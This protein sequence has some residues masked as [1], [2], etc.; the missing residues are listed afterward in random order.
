MATGSG[1]DAQ[2]GTK[3]ETTVGTI[4][5]PVDH[6]W[7]FA[8]AGLT[9]DPTY[10]EGSGI[11]AGQRFKD[12]N[13]VG[14]ARKSANGQIVI[15][16]LHAMKWGWWWRHLIG[17]V[18]APVIIGAGPAYKQVH[19][20]GP[21]KGISFTAQVGKPEPATGTVQPRTYPG[22]K[23]TDWDL[24]FS[25]GEAT[26]LSLSVDGWDED[27]VTG[28]AAASYTSSAQWNFAH[29][30]VF[31]TGGTASFASGEVSIAGGVAVPS[32][33]S[34]LTISGKNTLETGRYGLGNAGLKKEQLEVD[35]CQIT[36]SFEAE[37]DATT[38]DSPFKT[39]NTI[40]IQVDSTGP[41]I[42]GSDAYLLSV[43]MPYCKITKAPSEVSGPGLV[44]TKGEFEVYGKNDQT[45]IA[46]LQIKIVSTDTTL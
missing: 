10:I 4:A 19:V 33:V 11:Y 12:V 44:S 16:A 45:A 31:K 9:Y 32:V 30:N 18:A 28:L 2:F 40:A 7:P 46:P 42:A 15:P 26:A 35:Q 13:L 17:S 39:G 3:T 37:Y 41:I 21:M 24:A 38:W 22:C 23:V 8:S 34:K 27:Q 14:I 1:L 20:P 43:I 5:A 36:G 25:D 29:V 6:F